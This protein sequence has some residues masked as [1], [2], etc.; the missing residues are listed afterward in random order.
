MGRPEEIAAL[1]VF[2]ASEQA[3]FITGTNYRIDGG[4]HASLN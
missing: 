1:I 2:L 3:A 4:A